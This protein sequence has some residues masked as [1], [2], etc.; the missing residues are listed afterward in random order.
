MAETKETDDHE[1]F[2]Y[3]RVEPRPDVNGDYGTYYFAVCL[4][5]GLRKLGFKAEL[6]SEERTVKFPDEEQ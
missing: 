1:H 5:D 4:W 3:V 6:Q 2:F